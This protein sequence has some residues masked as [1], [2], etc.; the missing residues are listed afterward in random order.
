MAFSVLNQ[1]L[2]LRKVGISEEKFIW[3]MTLIFNF[4]LLGVTTFFA[5]REWKIN[6]HQLKT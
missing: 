5:W 6:I 2:F 3:D 4:Y 1:A